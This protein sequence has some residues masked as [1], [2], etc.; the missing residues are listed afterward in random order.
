MQEALSSMQLAM[1]RSYQQTLRERNQMEL[2]GRVAEA[3]RQ[4]EERGSLPHTHTSTPLLRARSVEINFKKLSVKLLFQVG[5]S[6]TEGGA[7][8]LSVVSVETS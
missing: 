7:C 4:E 3:V 5:S 1:L 6:R 8:G 2:S